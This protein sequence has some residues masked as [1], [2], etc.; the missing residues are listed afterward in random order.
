MDKVNS[1]Y[2]MYFWAGH[3]LYLGTVIDN[4]EHMHH[5]LQ[6]IVNREGLFRLR[7]GETSIECGGVVISPDRPHQLLSTSASQVHL[8]IDR[9]AAVAEAIASRHLGEGPVKILDG[10]LLK[11]LRGCIDVSGNFLGPC[12]QASE[13]YGKLVTELGGHAEK[14]EATVDPRIETAVQLIKETYLTRKVRLA[15]LARHACLSKSHLSHMF[16]EQ[17]G[18]P[19]RR[20]VLW[21]RL[22]TAFQFAVQG[23]SFTEAAHSAGFS[24]SAH[25]SRTY[26][27]MYGIS[28]S[29]CIK[30]HGGIQVFSCLS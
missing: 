1:Q 10:A 24:D 23:K 11:R 4:C 2:C 9:E 22:M 16:V 14:A 19:P 13:V 3:F 5:A 8:F 18:I 17:I 25:L 7:I 28:L 29:A 30:N 20:Y 6:V 26:K 12:G 21:R 27:R 15:E